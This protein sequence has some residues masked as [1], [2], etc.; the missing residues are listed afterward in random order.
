MGSSAEIAGREQS[1]F[2]DVNE[3]IRALGVA[4]QA[5]FLCECTDLECLEPISLEVSEYERIRL[6][7]TR[8]IV[9]PGHVIPDIERVI[10]RGDEYAVVEKFGDAGSAAV[11]EDPRRRRVSMFT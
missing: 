11:A 6:I 10:E 9:R 5:Q 7:P 4:D 3:R 8:F 1:L 2:R